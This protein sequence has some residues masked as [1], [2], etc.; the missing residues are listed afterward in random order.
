MPPKKEEK[1]EEKKD[2]KGGKAVKKGGAATSSGTKKRKVEDEANKPSVRRANRKKRFTAKLAALLGE[3]SNIMLVNVDNVGSNQMQNIRMTLRNKAVLLMGKNT[4]MRKIIRDNLKTNPKLEALLPYVV[5]NVGFVFTNGD[6]NEIR[7]TIQENKVPAAAKAGGTAPEDVVVPAGP[8]GMDPGQTAFFQVLQIP[9]KIAKGTIEITSNVNLIKKG[10]KVSAS[11]VALLAKL[12]IKP[13]FYGIIVQ[14]VFEDGSVYAASVLDL[15]PED[16]L[17]SFLTGVRYLAAL[18]LQVGYPSAATLPHS[19]AQGFKFV[20]AIS[21]ATE[22][23][24]PES[25]KFK[26]YLANPSAFAVAAPVGGGVKAAEA[27]PAAEEPAEEEDDGDFFG[28][29]LFD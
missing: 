5:G 22:Y 2:A 18:G 20:L 15:K 12:D 10:D 13:F 19:F 26:D 6:M 27:A 25:Q 4:M 3:Y 24:F 7:N 8:T 9:T 1:K 17:N 14:T 16:L 21:L 29:G 11:A 28:G 23:T